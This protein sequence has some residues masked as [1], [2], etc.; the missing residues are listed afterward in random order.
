MDRETSMPRLLTF[1]A[2]GAIAVVATAAT[3]QHMHMMDSGGAPA[4][5]SADSRVLMHFPA[6]MQTQM[7]KNMRDHVETLDAIMS[8]V[9]GGDYAKASTIAKERLGLDSPSAAGCK[10]TVA[11]AKPPP[12]DSMDAM[13]AQYMPSP[14]RAIGLSMHTAA[15]DF[16]DVAARADATHDTSA[17]LLALSRITPNCV[18]CHTAYRLR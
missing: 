10:P 1:V 12:S 2:A 7:L 9:A 6:M 14:M 8:A 15:S 3:A 17:V 4:V 13:M 5:S 11:G 16:A 18:A